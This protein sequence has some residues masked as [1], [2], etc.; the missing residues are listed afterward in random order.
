MSHSFTDA[1][2]MQA[3]QN[4]LQNEKK[5][6][7][8]K[9]D[10]DRIASICAEICRLQ[11]PEGMPDLEKQKQELTARLSRN[12]QQ[13]SGH[14]HI[15]RAALSAACIM[16]IAAGNF[17][18]VRAYGVNLLQAAYE[19]IGSGVQ[20]NLSAFQHSD[21]A[22]DVRSNLEQMQQICSDCGFSPLLPQYLPESLT[23]TRSE[24]DHSPYA[25]FCFTDGSRIAELTFEQFSDGR[26]A[27]DVT[28]GF[29]T[30]RCH[31]REVQSDGTK[32]LIS[33]EDQQF[34]A[35]FLHGQI[36]YTVF[37]ENL[38]YEEAHR[39]LDSFFE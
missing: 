37:T 15:L 38:D 28:A 32:I 8:A 16:S 30:D 22:S 1:Q 23:L 35:F 9:R 21:A 19:L 10:Y 12:R 7:P 3:L 25:D 20:C 36:L 14:I 4:S 29:P 2:K 13:S 17:W 27:G 39:I 6:P 34:T 31:I 11:H 24:T 33:W 26:N 5:K 18:S